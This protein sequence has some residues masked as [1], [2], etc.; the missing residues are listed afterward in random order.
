MYAGMSGPSRCSVR[1]SIRSM[2]LF[3]NKCYRPGISEI[4]MAGRPRTRGAG[5]AAG[6][7]LARWRA[8]PKR[9]PGSPPGGMGA[10]SA[11]GVPA[12]EPQPSL[13]G[14][15]CAPAEIFSLSCT[16]VLEHAWLWRAHRYM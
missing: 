13:A 6:R 8:S 12:A 11:G 14:R 16:L 7:R 10:H 1:L 3:K 5:E 15:S 4:L 2:L 9:P